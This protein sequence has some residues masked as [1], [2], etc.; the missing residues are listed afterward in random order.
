MSDTPE[1]MTTVLVIE[2]E[3][4]MRRLLRVLPGKKWLRSGGSGHGRRGPRRRPYEIQPKVVAA[5]PGVARY[6]RDDRAQA[7]CA[8]GAKAPVPDGLGAGA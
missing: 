5:G 6:G 3:V 7:V 2:D 4:Q 8:N 1:K